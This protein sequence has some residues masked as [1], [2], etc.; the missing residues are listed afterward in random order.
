MPLIPASEALDLTQF[1]ITQPDNPSL[2]YYWDVY[3]NRMT[4]YAD[5][6]GPGGKKD[7]MRQAIHHILFTE[8]YKWKI[9]SDNY[10]VELADLFG[11]PI[12]YC[13]PMIKTRIT[14]ALTADDRIKDVTDW[15]FET[16]YN[17]VKTWFTVVTIFGNVSEEMEVPLNV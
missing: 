16:D 7:C 3:T 2:T 8:R 1:N 6:S 13:I 17:V 10:G 4:G 15:T 11:Q 5:K 9:Y 14:E 12:S